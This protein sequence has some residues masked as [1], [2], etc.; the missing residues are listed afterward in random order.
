MVLASIHWYHRTCGTSVAVAKAG[1]VGKQRR[2]EVRLEVSIT[3]VTTRDTATVLEVI[4]RTKQVEVGAVV[5]TATSQKSRKARSRTSSTRRCTE[6]LL[7][8]PGK[9]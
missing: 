7:V 4:A 2:S 6:P 5:P 8:L 9:G 1:T 3:V